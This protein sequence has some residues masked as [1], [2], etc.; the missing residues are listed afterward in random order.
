MEDYSVQTEINPKNVKPFSAKKRVLYT[1]FT[2]Q[3]PV[4]LS[5]DEDFVSLAK[6]IVKK[7]TNPYLQAKMIYD[8]MLENFSLSKKL[9]DSGADSKELLKEKK[10]DAYDFAVVYTTLLRA[11]KIPALP[12]SGILV[13]ADLQSTSHWWC[14][15]YIENFG[16]VPVDVALG[17][18][19]EY[20]PF[21]NLEDPQKF[22]FGNLDSQHIIFTR[23]YNEVKPT[24]S[25]GH[26]V[27]RERTFALQSIWEE[28]STGTV[29]YSSLWNEPVIA[30]IY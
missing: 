7:E 3:D 12:V 21:K 27:R 26:S 24:L 16:W 18:G 8:Y 9:R 10:G 2:K 11:L 4:I 30:G 17:A 23:G 28:S 15:F 19:L 6:N 22:Y 14:E 5:E 1:A 20:K 25:D 13:D 29:N